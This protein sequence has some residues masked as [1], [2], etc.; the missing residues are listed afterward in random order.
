[1]LLDDAGP[2]FVLGVG[3]GGGDEAYRAV[4][5]NDGGEAVTVA[6]AKGSAKNLGSSAVYCF[7][8][9]AFLFCLKA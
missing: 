2:H 5:V 1:M 6:D 7:K 9:G 3:D 4:T 8:G